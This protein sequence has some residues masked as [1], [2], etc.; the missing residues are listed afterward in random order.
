MAV[1]Q[2]AFTVLSNRSDKAILSLTTT[3]VTTDASG[4]EHKL[5][6]SCDSFLTPDLRAVVPNGASVLVGPQVLVPE[7]LAS[8]YGAKGYFGAINPAVLQ[9]FANEYAGASHVKVTIDSI[10]FDD[11]E[12]VGPDQEHYTTE[13]EARKSAATRIAGQLQASVKNGQPLAESVYHLTPTPVPTVQSPPGGS[14]LA[15]SQES[16]WASHFIRNLQR[17]QRLGDDRR[18]QAYLAYMERLPQPV[19]MYR[20]PA[21]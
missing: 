19:K 9:Q 18:L 5:V 15:S 21:Q 13:I 12:V 1:L 14:S 10:V 11:G 3:W 7:S 6:Y 4:K 20:R 16:T 8:Q 2:P 17:A